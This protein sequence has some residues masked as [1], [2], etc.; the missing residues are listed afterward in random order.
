MDK[1]MD[2]HFGFEAT[3]NI[4]G[5]LSTL[6]DDAEH[7]IVGWP[8]GPSQGREQARPFYDAL[9]A[10]LAGGKVETIRRLYGADFLI[11]ESMWRG[12]APGRPFG[13]EG[14]DRSLAFRLLHVIRFTDAGAIQGEQVWVDLAAIQQQLPSQG[15][16]A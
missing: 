3:D 10:D 2:E 6:A 1:K 15:P 5:V 12:R 14:K 16:T 9:F 4:N 11:D 8:F 7:D 13:I